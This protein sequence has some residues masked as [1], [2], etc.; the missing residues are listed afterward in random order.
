L[1][2]AMGREPSCEM[3]EIEGDCLIADFNKRKTRT[4]VLPPC[5]RLAMRLASG[6]R[7]A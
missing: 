3:M 1:Y 4:A 5:G 6:R 7:T 2:V